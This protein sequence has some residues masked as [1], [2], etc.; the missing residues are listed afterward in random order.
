MSPLT[1]PETTVAYSRMGRRDPS[2]EAHIM[3]YRSGHGDKLILCDGYLVTVKANELFRE[4]V[5]VI[6]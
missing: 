2:G 4:V 3:I 6:V 5:R 1:D